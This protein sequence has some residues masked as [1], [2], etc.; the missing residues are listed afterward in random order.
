MDRET[1]LARRRTKKAT[2]G[3]GRHMRDL[4]GGYTTDDDLETM[5]L[6]TTLSKRFFLATM[7]MGGC[8]NC[9]VVH[10]IGDLHLHHVEEKGNK[11]QLRLS[12][13]KT[14]L[15]ELPKCVVLCQGC[16]KAHHNRERG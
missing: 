5:N 13:W 3:R 12:S 16:H 6:F 2:K 15:E 14:I 7:R 8:V 4:G 11:H 1:Y 9:D 10:P